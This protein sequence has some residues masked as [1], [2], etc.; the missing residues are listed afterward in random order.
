MGSS[1]VHIESSR[2][3]LIEY[4]V[5]QLTMENKITR[6][7]LEKLGRELGISDK[8]EVKELTELGVLSYARKIIENT[9]SKESYENLVEL[10]KRQPNS[11]YRSTD[12]M[13][14]QQYSTPLPIGYLL[15]Q[16]ISEKH[17]NGKYFEPSAGNGLLTI[18][19]KV[20]QTHVNEL[21][22][23]RFE[24]LKKQDYWAWTNYDATMPM[25]GVWNNYQGVISNPPFGRLKDIHSFKGVQLR[26]L[27]HLMILRAL[28][29]LEA[30]GRAAFVMGGHLKFDRRGRISIPNGRFFFN[31]L[32][33]EYHVVDMIQVDGNALYAR[34]GTGQDVTLI[35]I[36]G[37][38][39][40]AT[41]AAPLKS[42]LDLSL[43][44]SHQALYGR[45]SKHWTMKKSTAELKEK[46]KEIYAL[47]KG[48]PLDGLDAPYNPTSDACFV[49]NTEVPD[50][51]AFEMHNALSQISE[52]VGGD[53]DNFVRHRLGYTTK[54]ELCNALSAEQIDAV[55]MAIYN[56][57]AKRQ[58]C[59]IGDQ[60]GIGK[61]RVAASVI[62]YATHQ[63]MKPVFLT[64][65]A[66]L[67]SDL[68]RDLIAI[69]AG[70]LRPFIVNSRESKTN[71]KDEKGNVLYKAP[72]KAEQKYIFDSGEL[73][74]YDF[75]MA[76]YSQFNAA[77][78]N[79]KK[80]FLQLVSQDQV[81]VM[82]ES[83]NASGTSNTGLF[84]QGIVSKTQSTIFLSATFAKRP[85]NMPVYALKTAI[86]DANMS[87]DTLVNAIASG[88][89]PLQE[90][91]ASQ[92]VS[93][94][95]MIRRQRS[96][97]GVEVE[98]RTLENKKVEHFAIA[99]NITEIMRLIIDF[100]REYVSPIIEQKDKVLA[101][102]GKEIRKRQGTSNA[103]VDNIP[104]FSKIFNVINQMLFSL[105][106]ND[107]ADVAIE[108]LKNGKKPIIAFAST[109]GSFLNQ[110][111]E[112]EGLSIGDGEQIQTDFALILKNGLDGV[113]RYTET[114]HNGEKYRESFLPENLSTQGEQAYYVILEKIK[115]VASGI[116]ISP[117]D[118][119][120]DRIHEAGYSTHEV[121]GRTLRVIYEQDKNTGTIVRRKKVNV[122]DAYASFNNNETD[123][124]L[125]NQSGS[126]G[127][128]AQAM[129]NDK[130]PRE[131]VKPR[132][133]IVLQMELN[134][135]TEIQKRG[136]I[137][138]TG[139]IYMPSYIYINSA[140]PAEQRLMM[141]LREKL[142]SLDANTS[143]DQNQNEKM[144][145]STDFLNKYGDKVIAEYL[146]EDRQL[147]RA[148]GE[149]DL[150]G[151]GGETAHRASG[152]IAVMPTEVQKRFYTEVTERYIEYVNYL[153]QTGEYDLE[154]ESLNFEATTMSKKIAVAGN[155]GFSKFGTDT[156][157]SL[158]EVNNLKKPFKEV[159]L[160][161]ILDEHLNGLSPDEYAKQLTND[162]TDYHIGVITASQQKINR[163]FDDQ[164]ADL[165]N[166]KKLFAIQKEEGT[167]AYETIIK[168]KREE[169][170]LS[171][172]SR[173]S[174]LD[175]SHKGKAQQFSALVN[176]FKVGRQ[177]RYTQLFREPILTIFLGFDINKGKSNPYAPSAIKL[178]FA[179]ASSLKYLVLPTSFAPEINNIK[180]A[181][182]DLEELSIDAVLTE[183]KTAIE[184]EQKNRVQRYMVTGNILQG[185]GRY[186]GKLVSYTTDKGTVE[187]GI[188]LPEH[189]SPN[190]EGEI[191]GVVVPLMR[192]FAH[193]QSQGYGKMVTLSHD[194]SIVNN[195]GQYTVRFPASKKRG[196]DFYLNDDLIKLTIENKFEKVS[197]TMRGTISAENFKAFLTKLNEMKVNIILSES[198]F[199][200]IEKQAIDNSGRVLKIIVPPEEPKKNVKLLKLKAK[201]VMI[202][203]EL[204]KIRRERNAA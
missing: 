6:L 163:K 16:F 167:A 157:L 117:I 144:I 92:L 5:E 175:I 125:I 142:K 85:E 71:I 77:V 89:V 81:M 115:S 12:S 69:G 127:A 185:L 110:V 83:H 147:H 33:T 14:L 120:L 75:I 10:Y 197:S 195:D 94:G 1:V 128:S 107:V 146:G 44:E 84:M 126:T 201:A 180:G 96:Y 202:E 97:E 93:E 191:R 123:V 106:A 53:I 136:R 174:E 57:E 66:N 17:P 23:L 48:K 46:A 4:V 145:N 86:S 76:T 135:D 56:I 68:Y 130:V 171:R 52:A 102:E 116:Y 111:L 188:L 189:Y 143:S 99:D 177:L 182:I 114:D 179:I 37:K 80:A 24:I 60:T 193:I 74:D 67:F 30:D 200:R 103:G 169:I 198:E 31:Y 78:M 40:V 41:G 172:A 178:K 140:I 199:E 155:G 70:H 49:L 203:L 184:K 47:L 20:N 124:L 45:I 65:K 55:A 18:G 170:E 72:T 156:Y 64:E 29:G 79:D 104:Y 131:E 88:G 51:M 164:L 34:Q 160:K 153:K 36:D 7:G 141:M 19:L 63:G 204:L 82:D 61:G 194:I 38:K 121:T 173:L 9:S 132:V 3:N 35:L 8:R 54:K 159:E 108:Q 129:P 112:E 183:W 2:N 148:L 28:E 62:R 190:Q 122:N 27:D 21:D 87:S 39:K 25:E 134:V 100:Q 90:I 133:M 150:N 101:E 176:F 154:V 181:S 95:Q 196:G 11:S 13:K 113:L 91:I 105:K 42:N 109:M 22:Q 166:D 137:Y 43:I 165:L 15:G 152:R 162:Y 119:I 151:S 168:V 59:I 158:L 32:Y 186:W 139:Q 138:R 161:N 187:K 26:Y 118:I 58:G 98:Y 192:A 73:D 149:P 50:T